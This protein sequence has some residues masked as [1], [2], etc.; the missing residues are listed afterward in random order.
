TERVLRLVHLEAR[1]LRDN[2][3]DTGHLLMAILKEENN[4]AT[5]LL[6]EKKVT[7]DSVRKELENASPENRADFPSDDDDEK[8]PFGTGKPGSSSQSTK[9]SSETPVLDNF[10]IDLT[11]AAEEGRLDPIVGREL[12]IERLAQ[13]LSRR[14]KNNPILIGEPGV[15]KSAIAEGLANRIIQ[16]K[17]SRVL[18]DKRVVTLDLASI[19]AGTKYRG[20]FEERVKAIL[21]EINKAQGKV[22]IFIDEIHTIVGAGAA[23]GAIDASNILKPPLARGELQCIGATTLGEYR[24]HIEKD[25]ALERRFQMVL[26]EEPSVEDTLK[27]L[28]GIAPR[29][30]NHHKVT[31]QHAALE[32]ASKLSAQYISGRFLPDKAIDLIDEA[33]AKVRISVL[34][35][36]P[37][38]KDLEQ[39]KKE[40]RKEKYD[41]AESQEFEKAAQ[42]RDEERQI[43]DQLNLKRENWHKDLEALNPVVTAEDI[44]EVVSDWTGVPTT[45]LM[46]EER[47]R[48]LTLE[49]VLHEKIIGQ[50]EAVSV[51]AKSLRRA[52]VGLAG[53]NRPIGSFMF[54]GPSGV[55]KTEL[56]RVLASHI[57]GSEKSLIR[58]DMSEY[59]EKYSVS[60]LVGAPPGYIGFEEGGQ[61][62]EKVRRKPFSVVLL[63]EIEK[64]HP[65]VFNILLQIMDD[66]RLTDSQG[67]IIDFK[68]TILIMT[69]NAG[70]QWKETR[71]LG[72]SADA[73][74]KNDE[75]EEGRLGDAVKKTFRP[76]FLGR[77]DSVVQFK[78]L[79]KEE[80]VQISKL[81][82]AKLNDS[83]KDEGLKIN[84]TDEAL[85]A[86]VEKSFDP[87][88]GARPLARA[89]QN[90]IEDPLAEKTLSGE[91]VSG[92]TII[93]DLKENELV[94]SK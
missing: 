51:V 27:I 46:Q 81:L 80:L 8:G 57:Y 70:T 37:E 56:A 59:M 58:V 63:D 47:E 74:A 44:A 9:T 40:L 33:S 92:D 69:S 62:T 52:R 21:D 19:V 6:H 72:F 67:R 76:E 3:I 60:R 18:F 73:E 86:L 85:N 66:G 45:R 30:E 22:I 31:I 36:P 41:A 14:K 48:L 82:I 28:I 12:E 64:A 61:L 4:F 65:D 91:F 35:L 39:R 17:V 54:V 90:L 50:D 23:E 2:L 79:T 11:K 13:I 68:Q 77:V 24:K 25:P 55:G 78:Q 75:K 26:V 88:L 7:Y 15:G 38:I 94:L 93:L 53:R 84:P 20:E 16:R 89:I 71:S 42:L 1:S 87:K 32:A 34:N 49:N 10:G 29:Y 5:Q 83:L 43:E